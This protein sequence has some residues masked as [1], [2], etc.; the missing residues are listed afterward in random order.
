[1]TDIPDSWPPQPDGELTPSRSVHAPL[2][3]LPGVFLF[4]RQLMA[5]HIFEPRYI[6]MIEDILDG[7]GRVILATIPENQA[8]QAM[9]TDNPPEVLPVAGMGEIARH[10]KLPEGRYAVWIFGLGRVLI[11]EVSSTR[12]YR[13]AACT[14]MREVPPTPAEAKSLEQPLRDA[15]SERHPEI[16]N[17]PDDLPMGLLVDLLCQRLPSNQATMESIFTEPNLL[18]RAQL[19]LAAHDITPPMDDSPPEDLEN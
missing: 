3:P 12:L 18:T 7:P 15:V 17:L 19:A 9:D 1:M 10:E 6:Q 14:P 2:F 11:E 8:E 13:A 4:P 5:L 16:L